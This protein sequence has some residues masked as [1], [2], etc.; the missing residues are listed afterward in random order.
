MDYGIWTSKALLGLGALT[1]LVGVTMNDAHAQS[2]SHH[3]ASPYV[4]LHDE[5]SSPW[6]LQLQPN[7]A[8]QQHHARQQRYQRSLSGR[9]VTQPTLQTRPG[10]RQAIQQASVEPSHQLNP[11]FLPQVVSYDTH[12]PVGTIIVDPHNRFL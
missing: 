6:L 8:R 10:Q 3:G 4:M 1:M 2:V 5:R 12:H 9:I 11:I 7:Y